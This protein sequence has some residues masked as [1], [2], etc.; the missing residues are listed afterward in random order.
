M[1][2]KEKKSTMLENVV[3]YAYQMKAKTGLPF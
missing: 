2:E 1:T 3:T